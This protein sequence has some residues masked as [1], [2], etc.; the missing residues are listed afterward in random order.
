MIDEQE[1]KRWLEM[2][3]Q[4]LPFD[5]WEE[6][7]KEAQ[8][9][10][11]LKVDSLINYEHPKNDN[12]RLLNLQWRYKHGDEKALDEMY[13]LSKTLCLKFIHT[14]GKHNRHVKKLPWEEKLIK[15]EDAASYLIEQYLKRPDFV[16]EKNIPGYLFLRV[17][18]ELFYQREVDKIVDYVDLNAFFK[19]G[20]E[21][22]QEE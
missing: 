7:K 20:E 16:A 10:M 2:K 4:V 15:A 5:F 8:L 6:E 11:A 12:Q 9:Q 14:I 18:K 13:E 1:R 22:P 21:D 19:E 3:Q 17:E